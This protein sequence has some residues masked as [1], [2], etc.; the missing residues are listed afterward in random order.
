MSDSS[1]KNL[2]SKNLS[3]AQMPP[4]K[5]T[6]RKI[7]LI[8]AIIFVLPFTVA[9]TLHLLNVHPSGH[10]YGELIQP[11]RALKL[12]ALQDTQ[13]TVFTAQQW[14]KKWNVVTFAT[15]TCDEPC[16]AQTHLLKQVQTSLNKDMHRLQRVLL[17]SGEIKNESFAALQKQYPDLILLAGDAAEMHQFA[18]SY[19][20]ASGDIYLVDPLGNLMMHYP[21]KM[22]P[23]GLRSD[24][25]RLLKNSW[26]G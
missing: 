20:M 3:G 11:P 25:T 13:G 4:N 10:S 17:V 15:A 23:K 2:S 22:D 7:L 21:N 24:L 26:A 6:G 16:Q 14:L 8:L 12:P 9:A 1:S 18:T 19:N 5:I